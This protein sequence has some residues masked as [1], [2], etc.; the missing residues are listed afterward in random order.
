MVSLPALPAA[1]FF[2]PSSPL[3]QFEPPPLDPYPVETRSQSTPMNTNKPTTNWPKEMRGLCS[4]PAWGA[5]GTGTSASGV[6][7]TAVSCTGLPHLPQKLSSSLSSAP[8]FVQ[9]LCAIR[10]LPLPMPRS[11]CILAPVPLSRQNGS[12]LV[13]LGECQCG[14][15]VGC[16]LYAVCTY[17]QTLLEGGV[18]SARLQRNHIP[19]SH[20]AHDP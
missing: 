4:S 9:Y 17:D 15:R 11:V 2:P 7:T 8:Q 6:D 5:G 19:S 10:M 12:P 16:E 3:L 13:D 1:A 20:L 14:E 18:G